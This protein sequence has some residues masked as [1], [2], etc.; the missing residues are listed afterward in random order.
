MRQKF[1][2]HAFNLFHVFIQGQTDKSGHSG[3]LHEM[4]K[5][6]NSENGELS[7]LYMKKLIFKIVDLSES[8]AFFNISADISTLFGI[9]WLA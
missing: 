9:H 6:L 4:K 8:A 7:N 1:F 2:I 3:Q 5:T